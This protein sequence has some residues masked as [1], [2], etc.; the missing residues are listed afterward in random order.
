ME[1]CE[2]RFDRGVPLP[3]R[4]LRV[5]EIEEIVQH[6]GGR[7]T[8]ALPKLYNLVI[9]VSGN[10]VEGCS[11]ARVGARPLEHLRR[12][13]MHDLR[14]LT[15][16]ISKGERPY[17]F[18]LISVVDFFPRSSRDESRVDLWHGRP[19]GK[20]APTSRPRAERQSQR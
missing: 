6:R 15:N 12:I 17:D 5:G 14:R 3:R 13:A 20:I 4:L 2:E 8:N 7:A 16:R 9:F 1:V 18:L 10:R 19:Q 11:E